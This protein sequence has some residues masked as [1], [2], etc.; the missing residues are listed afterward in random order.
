MAYLKAPYGVNGIGLSSS[1][2]LLHPAMGYTSQ[3]SA[4]PTGFTNTGASPGSGGTPRKQR[5]ER[6]TFTRAQLEVLE[7]LFAKTRYP[8]I[9]MR[10]EVAM[11]INL[12]ES[13]VQVWFK[14]RRAKCRQQQQTTNN[15][16]TPLAVTAKKP[17]STPKKHRSSTS[18]NMPS[19][20]EDPSPKQEAMVNDFAS[21]MSLPPASSASSLWNP[22]T[23]PGDYFTQNSCM[24]RSMYSNQ[25]QCYPQSYSSNPPYFDTASSY[26]A[27]HHQ[28]MGYQTRYAPDPSQCAVADYPKVEQTSHW[29]FQAL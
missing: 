25:G 24:Q 29:K 17:S 19:V 26:I 23:I 9:F 21:K 14:N 12:P 15:S 2:D 11:K 1:V 16:G 6:T 28:Y 13:R 3:Y 7:T 5:R 4:L 18:P 10:E 22:A 20:D 8:D 27:P